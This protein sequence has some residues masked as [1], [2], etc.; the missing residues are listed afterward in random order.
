MPK[1]MISL[2]LLSLTIALGAAEP[3]IYKTVDADGNV[4]FT[5]VPPRDAADA[6]RISK[7]NNYTP[8]QSEATPEPEADVPPAGQDQPPPDDPAYVASE[9]SYDHITIATPADDAAVRENAGNLSVQVNL[10]PQLDLANGHSIQLMLN[11]NLASSGTSTTLSIT[12]VDRGTHGLV[13]QVVNATGEILASSG[14]ITF[15]MLRHSVLF[16]RPQRN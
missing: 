10:S 16:N 15:H 3:A 1:K 11:G 9:V 12:N 13:A 8:T 14:P 6:V 5:D 2:L 4:I 7:G